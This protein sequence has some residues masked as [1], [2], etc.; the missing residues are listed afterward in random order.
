MIGAFARHPTA[1]NLLMIGFVVLGL[2]ALPNMR[3]ES[4]PEFGAKKVRVDVV[5]P[6]ATASEVEEAICQ[7][8][9]DAVDEVDR[10]VVRDR[11]LLDHACR[12][13]EEALCDLLVL[14]RDLSLQLRKKL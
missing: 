14:E 4:F 7:R 1:A 2:T 12:D 10:E 9:E 5:Y 3:R 11:D 13:Q 8:I 6:G